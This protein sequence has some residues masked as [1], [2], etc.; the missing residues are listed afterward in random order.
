MK[1]KGFALAVALAAMLLGACTAIPDSGVDIAA[2]RQKLG[3]LDGYK[4][5]MAVN[6]ADTQDYDARDATVRSFSFGVSKQLVKTMETL[7]LAKEYSDALDYSGG[8]L[9][10]H[11]MLLTYWFNSFDQLS[12]V[13]YSME[14]DTY[15][16]TLDSLMPAL[17]AGY[18]EPADAGYYDSADEAVTF[19][20]K[21][22]ALDAVAEGNAYY[23]ALFVQSNGIT[24]EL[25]ARRTDTGYDYWVYFTDYDYYGL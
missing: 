25:Y 23:Y 20:T 18:G 8:A 6:R 10:G 1:R 19:D 24:I 21:A 2:V 12:C 7:T 3:V 22:A 9:Y 16:D 14:N 5:A 17:R 4:D 15:A 13:S 11:D